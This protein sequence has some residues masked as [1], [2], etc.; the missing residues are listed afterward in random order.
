MDEA[1]SGKT[2][3][4][5]GKVEAAMSDLSQKSGALTGKV[6]S[7]SGELKSKITL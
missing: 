2:A 6:K 3:E 5:T 1:I 4:I 7:L